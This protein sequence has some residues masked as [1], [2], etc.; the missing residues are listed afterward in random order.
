MSNV[1][2]EPTEL[3]EPYKAVVDA[4]AGPGWGVFPDFLPKARVRELAL[5]C[6]ALWD[7]GGFRHAGIGNGTG[8]GL[9]ET[10]RSDRVI[11][12]NDDLLTPVQRQWTDILDDLRLA[13]NRSLYLGLYE[14]EGHFAVYPPGSFYKRHLDQ[15]KDISLRTVTAI[16]YLNEDWQPEDGGKLR[17]YL[18]ADEDSSY[19]D[20]S[21]EAGTLVSFLS[22][23]FVHEVLP[24]NRERMS[25]TGWYR[26][27]G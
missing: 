20:V 19:V 22:G 13:I 21:P 12:L 11:W 17:L 3:N 14:F 18:E 8:H 27:R 7:A 24:A 25:L 9:H 4:L 6:R 2:L 23:S 10:I 5:E 15:F 1:L 26:R 16:L